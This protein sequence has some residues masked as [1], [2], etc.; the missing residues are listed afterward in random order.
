MNRGGLG[1]R[2]LYIALQAALNLSGEH[3][4]ER[5]G[6]TF[7]VGDKVMQIENGNERQVSS[8]DTGNVTGLDLDDGELLA[9]VGGREVI[10]PLANSI[11][12]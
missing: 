7:A 11:C 6:S 1:A 5:F 9:N 3:K 10:Y 2:S 12:W 4:V 8:C